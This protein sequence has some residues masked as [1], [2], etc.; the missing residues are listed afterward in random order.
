MQVLTWLCK[1]IARVTLSEW[2]A[3]LCWSNLSSH[4]RLSAL[5]MPKRNLSSTL[6]LFPYTVKHLLEDKKFSLL[7]WEHK[8]PWRI[9]Q[10]TLIAGLY[11]RQCPH[12]HSIP[13]RTA[14]SLPRVL[15]RYSKKQAWVCNHYRG[16]AVMW[17]GWKKLSYDMN[18]RWSQIARHQQHRPSCK[19][20]NQLRKSSWML[21]RTE[22]VPFSVL[23]SLPPPASVLAFGLA[24]LTIKGRD[25]SMTSPFS[26]LTTGWSPVSS[27]KSGVWSPHG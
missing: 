2:N 26:S 3:I 25:E 5:C 11:Y 1:H 13:A 20:L 12:C 10:A 21:R 15:Q 6:P 22:G 4:D 27:R 7:L 19:P 14:K 18:L 17:S 23:F 8:R 16:C 24:G 9:L